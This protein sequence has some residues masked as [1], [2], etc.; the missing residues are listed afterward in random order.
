RVM[1]PELLYVPYRAQ[2]DGPPIHVLFRDSRLSNA[3]GFEYQNRGAEEAATDL[4]DR[5][6][7]IRR[8]QDSAW[9]AVIALDGENCWDFYEGNGNAFLH[10]LYRRLSHDPDLK[11]VTVSEFL[12]EFPSQRSLARIHPGSWINANFD[13]WVG[14]QEHNVAW[15]LLG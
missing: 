4:L 9:L 2:T 5:L 10:S 3:I 15:E 8:R 12:A 1:Q 14:D 7:D 6:H 13:T 11:T